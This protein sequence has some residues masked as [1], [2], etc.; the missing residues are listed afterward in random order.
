[1]RNFCNLIYLRAVVFQLNLKYLYVLVKITNLLWVVIKQISAWFICDIGLGH[2]YHLWYF[3]VVSYFTR[4]TA[5][6]NTYNNFEISLMVCQTW[7][8]IMLLYTYTNF[9]NRKNPAK[10]NYHII[11]IEILNQPIVW[12]LYHVFVGHKSFDV[13]DSF[14]D[15][16]VG[17]KLYQFYPLDAPFYD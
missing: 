13:R 11:Y 4:V 10:P 14:H 12:F 16:F 8:Q 3:K 7:L 5:R 9:I 1:M 15:L 2:K 6:E 17:G